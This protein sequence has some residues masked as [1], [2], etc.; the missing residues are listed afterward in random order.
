MP[1]CWRWQV[2]VRRRSYGGRRE[3]GNMAPCRPAAWSGRRPLRS[4]HSAASAFRPGSDGVFPDLGQNEDADGARQIAA[5]PRID[6]RDQGV[7]GQPTI[8]CDIFQGV[9]KCVFKGQARVMARHQ[10][11]SFGHAAGVAGGGFCGRMGAIHGICRIMLFSCLT[12]RPRAVFSDIINND[13]P[14]EEPPEC[15][16]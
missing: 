11:G 10:D 12:A 3:P 8:M 1:W 7:H 4:V 2:W 14:E 5:A 13:Q 15:R 6:L 16:I 9:P